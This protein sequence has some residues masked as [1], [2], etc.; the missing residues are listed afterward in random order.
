MALRFT[1][2][3]DP[4]SSDINQ[5][6]YYT[7]DTDQA[8]AQI[9]DREIEAA[10]TESTNP[11]IAAAICLEAL[12]SKYSMRAN[13]TVGEVSEDLGEISEKLK[14]A[15][16]AMRT[17]AGKHALPFFGGLTKSGKVS[18]NSDSDAVQNSFRKGMFDNQEA[19]QFDDTAED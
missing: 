14:A 19:S 12:S 4:T 16:E 10:L 1:Y 3:G 11:R 2:D 15:A 7:G 8:T 9:D 6:R 5:V 17:E 18:L 13:I